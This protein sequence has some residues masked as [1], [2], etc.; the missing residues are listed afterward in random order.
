MI[1]IKKR[2]FETVMLD[3]WAQLMGTKRRWFGMESDRDLRK[4]LERI[5]RKYRERYN[6]LSVDVK[7]N[8]DGGFGLTFTI[9]V[10]KAVEM[11]EDG[12]QG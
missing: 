5:H 10:G 12:E 2:P 6:N 1:R 11:M 4:R 3:R 7:L 9:P 8:D